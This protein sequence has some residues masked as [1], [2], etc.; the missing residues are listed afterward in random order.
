M[1]S[2]KAKLEQARASSVLVSDL[3][4]ADKLAAIETDRRRMG[5]PRRGIRC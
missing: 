1:A 2:V 5:R 3:P 4:D